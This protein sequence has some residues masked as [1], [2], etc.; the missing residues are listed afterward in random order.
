MFLR[1]IQVALTFTATSIKY[2]DPTFLYQDKARETL[3]RD[4][5]VVQV[6]DGYN[7]T[8]T[9][10]YGTPDFANIS[11]DGTSIAFNGLVLYRNFIDG[12]VGNAV[13]A[14]ERPL[15]LGNKPWKTFHIIA[16]GEIG[17]DPTGYTEVYKEGNT[18]VVNTSINLVRGDSIG[19]AVIL[20]V[21]EID[22]IP[23]GVF[24]PRYMIPADQVDTGAG[25]YGYNSTFDLGVISS[26]N[27][28]ELSI[29]PAR[30]LSE[31]TG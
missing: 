5:S 17:T 4:N 10:V 14:N 30:K 2:N 25:F 12:F 9:N 8:V 6:S 3:F 23:A 15:N 20:K 21:V 27:F 18:C 22:P 1:L 19:D 28:T 29:A 13:D 7:L 31:L 11:G 16:D 24:R 26:V